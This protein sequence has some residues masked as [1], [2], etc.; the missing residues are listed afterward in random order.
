MQD[1]FPQLESQCTNCGMGG[2]TF[3]LLV[4]SCSWFSYEVEEKKTP[5]GDENT[6][7]FS[8]SAAQNEGY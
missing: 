5:E 3:G 6:F 8:S 2:N 7:S 1:Q 4:L